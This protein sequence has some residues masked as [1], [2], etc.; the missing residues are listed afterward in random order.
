M[1]Q[2]SVA[3]FF[4][5]SP[6]A[7]SAAFQAGQPRPGFAAAPQQASSGVPGF[8]TAFTSNSALPAAGGPAASVGGLLGAPA[9]GPSA[10]PNGHP[11]IAPAS[12]SA[13][14]QQMFAGPASTPGPAP[15]GPPDTF[16]TNHAAPSTG[17]PLFPTPVVASRPALTVQGIGSPA[18]NLARLPPGPSVGAPVSHVTSGSFALPPTMPGLPRAPL[19]T[20]GVYSGTAAGQLPSSAP[21]VHPS[22]APASAPVPPFPFQTAPIAS[23]APA[24]PFGGPG[25]LQS[26]HSG[27]GLL[28]AAAPAPYSFPPTGPGQAPFSALSSALPRPAFMG[29]PAAPSVGSLLSTGD[30]KP[31][32]PFLAARPMGS[33]QMHVPA[34]NAAPA[35]PNG[36][37][38]NPV[39]PRGPAIMAPLGATAAPSHGASIGGPA[40]MPTSNV[41]P[42]SFPGLSGAPS[43]PPGVVATSLSS[44]VAGPAGA[45]TQPP[46]LAAMP[47]AAGPR[48]GLSGPP[49]HGMQPAAPFT[50]PFGGQTAPPTGPPMAGPPVPGSQLPWQGQNI[51]QPGSLVRSGPPTFNGPPAPGMTANFAMPPTG[52]GPPTGLSTH[53]APPTGFSPAPGGYGGPPVATAAYAQPT[54][55]APPPLPQAAQARSSAP[56]PRIDPNA[57]PR[58]RYTMPLRSVSY[59]TTGEGFNVPPASWS[60]YIAEDTGNVNP[61]F[62]RCTMGHVPITK[63]VLKESKIPLAVVVNAIA[64]PGYGEHEVAF[65]ADPEG[66][67]R[68]GR[69]RG[70]MNPFVRWEEGGNSW[71]CNL[72]SASNETPEYYRFPIDQYGLRSD[73]ERRPELSQSS[74]EFVAPRSFCVRNPAPLC[75]MFMVEATLTSVSS[76][77]FTAALRAVEA[78]LSQLLDY[79]DGVARAGIAI[80][81]SSL[82]FFDMSLSEPRHTLVLDIDDSFC[83]LAPS[84]C[85]PVLS[86][87]KQCWHVLLDKLPE[88]FTPSARTAVQGC[89]GSAVKAGVDALAET[90][91]RLVVFQ[92]TIPQQGEGKLGNRERFAA[93]GSDEERSL[94]TP[95]SGHASSM[96]YSDLAKHAAAKG[97]CV[98]HSV[99]TSSNVDLPTSAVLASL[100]GGEVRLYPYFSFQPSALPAAPVGGPPKPGSLMPSK[101]AEV[102]PLSA[103]AVAADVQEKISQEVRFIHM[104]VAHCA[105]KISSC[106]MQIASLFTGEVGTEAVLKLRTSNGLRVQRFMG[107]FCDRADTEADLGG[108]DSEKSLL[109]VLQHDGNTIKEGEDLHVQ[110]ALLFT[111]AL[112]DRRI[113][114][115]NLRLVGTDNLQAVFRHADI[116][117]I[118]AYMV[119]EGW[120]STQTMLLTR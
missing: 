99:L 118:V 81:D 80:F 50:S 18:P 6:A 53:G 74:V 47:Y 97:V 58:P 106:C 37:P 54:M 115:H 64:R 91:G 2:P 70:Y 105:M 101:P 13:G 38:T 4:A 103:V 44:F 36:V 60:D 24:G 108:L 22:V 69:C 26:S 27:S 1:A 52:M 107:N 34:T 78:A 76:G 114:V 68:C 8:G 40:A 119:R 85:L 94:Y 100:T 96:F 33:A 111:T 104:C 5:S 66:P 7:P 15:S 61:R 71:V 48:P 62:V 112:G 29:A 41:R 55:S 25:S 9:G 120:C 72:C 102:N 45:L 65:S 73:R 31:A 77:A 109:A 39:G 12:S 21:G 35:A 87:A 59:K 16:A 46:N 42:P 17:A 95:V 92:S 86:N 20:P 11:G 84:Q 32:M 83:P 117:S 93:Y 10:V 14:A 19:S 90:G 28:P 116:D 51:P 82:H 113:R 30:V 23:T 79:G 56:A 89:F 49:T 63:D 88:M 110:V 57:I 3:S 43:L 75:V 67:V 98:V